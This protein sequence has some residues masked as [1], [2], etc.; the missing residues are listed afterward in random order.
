MSK[1]LYAIKRSMV[2]F[3]CHCDPTT[4]CKMKLTASCTHF[5][6]SMVR[7]SIQTK[8]FTFATNCLFSSDLRSE[9]YFLL[10]YPNRN[11]HMSLYYIYHFCIH[12]P[13]HR[14]VRNP[15]VMPS[16]YI[17]VPRKR[18]DKMGFDE[19]SMEWCE[20]GVC[21]NGPLSTSVLNNSPCSYM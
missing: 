6:T 16:K 1:C 15:P 11:Q 17:R 3:R 2:T 4:L 21:K 12:L 8:G 14:V 13:S 18:P 10:F 19:V 7:S 5:W 20:D 9:F